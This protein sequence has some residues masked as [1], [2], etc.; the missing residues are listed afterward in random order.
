[1]AGKGFFI[2]AENIVFNKHY[3]LL[4]S[5]PIASYSY[6]LYFAQKVSLNIISSERFI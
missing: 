4:Q 1:M 5:F 3:R 6:L 2:H